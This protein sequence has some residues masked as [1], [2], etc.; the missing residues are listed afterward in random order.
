MRLMA[1]A[2]SHEKRRAAAFAREYREKEGLLREHA[3][4]GRQIVLG[5]NEQARAGFDVAG[6]STPICL[7]KRQELL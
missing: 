3:S 7:L 1:G 5:L 6:A 4:R 2:S